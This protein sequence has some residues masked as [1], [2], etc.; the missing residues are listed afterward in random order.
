MI[1]IENIS[2]YKDI[3]IIPVISIDWKEDVEIRLCWLFWGIFITFK[4]I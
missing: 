3:D 2:D 1:C 4:N